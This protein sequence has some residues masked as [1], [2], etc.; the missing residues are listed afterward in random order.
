MVRSEDRAEWQ[1]S[2]LPTCE[3]KKPAS[4]FP[5]M[6]MSI[7]GTKT[8]FRPGRC[9]SRMGLPPGRGRSPVTAGQER[10]AGAVAG[11]GRAGGGPPRC[12]PLM[13]PSRPPPSPLQ[14]SLETGSTR[15][16]SWNT[17]HERTLLPLTMTYPAP[18]RQAQ[19]STTASPQPTTRVSP[20]TQG[21]QTATHLLDGDN[22]VGVLVSGLVNRGKLERKAKITQARGKVVCLFV[23][24]FLL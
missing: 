8:C 17:R 19:A 4:S 6:S 13:A 5:F 2:A 24:A 18:R 7:N 21:K 12:L 16:P 11:R 20:E 10:V 15:V 14:K 3:F 1:L 22:L 23:S 9:G